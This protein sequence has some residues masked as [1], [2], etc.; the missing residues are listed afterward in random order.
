MDDRPLAAS[1]V[2]PLG[3][4]QRQRHLAVEPRV[5]HEEDLLRPPLVARV[6]PHL[7][8]VAGEALGVGWGDGGGDVGC[9]FGVRGWGR[10]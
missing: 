5:P 3:A 2:E 8:A 10:W 7:L 9:A 1:G 6:S 4:Q